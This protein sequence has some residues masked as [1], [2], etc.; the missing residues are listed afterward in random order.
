MAVVAS[1]LW[2]LGLMQDIGHCMALEP[3]LVHSQLDVYVNLDCGQF[4]Y[5]TVCAPYWNRV[6]VGKKQTNSP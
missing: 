1:H 6:K 3:G 4:I 2:I 5:V